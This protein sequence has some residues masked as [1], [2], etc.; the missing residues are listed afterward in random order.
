MSGHLRANLWLLGL[1]V[2][3]CCV[4]YPL[5]LWGIGQTLFPSSAAGSLVEDEKGTVRG[6]RLI[7]QKFTDDRYFQ[8]RPSAVDYN[9]SASGASN[10]GASN[11]RLRFRVARQ[12]GPMVRYSDDPKNG[13][14]RGQPVGPFIERWFA[15]KDRVAEWAA[16]NPTAAGEWVKTDDNTKKFVTEWAGA[17]ADVLERWKADN[18]GAD[19]PDPKKNPEDL[20]VAFFASFAAKHPRTFPG[21]EEVKTPDGKTEKRMGPVKTGPDLQGVF[22]DGWLR[23]HAD[24]DLEKVPADMVMTSGSGLDPHITLRNARLQLRYTVA[25]AW[26]KGTGRDRKR[27]SGQI[28]EILQKHAFTPLGGLVGE[29]LVNVL[30]VNL[31]LEDHFK[32]PAGK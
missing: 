5:V 7:A 18:P 13:G 25:D 2:L 16:A 27:V 24:A 26:A 19:A 21:L 30:E 15:E 10:Y 22:F 3:I 1:T 8:P 12:L 28:E 31:A 4:L 14:R 17:H 32:A 11:P 9:A 20:A 23:E 6:S 29:P